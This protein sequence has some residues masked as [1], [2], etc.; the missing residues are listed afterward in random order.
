MIREF[1]KHVKKYNM[2]DKRIYHKFY[3]SFDTMKICVYLAKKLKLNK[4]DIKLAKELGL[5]HDIGRFEQIK[6]YNSMN[7]KKFKNHGLI[8]VNIL[9]DE[10]YL[11]EFNID[12]KHYDIIKVAIINHAQNG[13][14]NGLT[15]KELLFCKLI[16]D[17]D[18]IAI[19]KV[20][21]KF[22]A[23]SNGEVTPELKVEFY[24][25]LKV[26]FDL[27]KT[28]ADDVVK[29]LSYTFDINFDCS[30]NY[31]K[32]KRILQKLE[33]KINNPKLKEYFNEVNKYIDE[34]SRENDGNK[35]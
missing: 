25:H 6:V 28:N 34:R 23:D 19:F 14:N 26:N 3:H 29:T 7:D 18:K 30:F 1:K 8:G 17:A 15:E 35:I 12:P 31:L 9:F 4:E 13:I 11:E 2:N 10:N 5:L 21:D 22:L 33:K 20:I 16:R 27:V 24:E 32:Q